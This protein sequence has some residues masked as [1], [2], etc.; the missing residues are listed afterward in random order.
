MDQNVVNNTKKNGLLKPN[1]Y[2]SL[3]IY[4]SMVLL[5]VKW[6]NNIRKEF[7]IKCILNKKDHDKLTEDRKMFL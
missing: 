6:R 1:T 3:R 7:A 5:E 4:I 2:A